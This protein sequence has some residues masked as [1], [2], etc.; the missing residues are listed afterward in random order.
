MVWGLIF[1][2]GVNFIKGLKFYIG[3]ELSCWGEVLRCSKNFMSGSKFRIG[4]VILG[5][6]ILEVGQFNAK[7]YPIGIKISRLTL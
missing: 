4:G 6:K 2:S 5:S 3:G 7:K 1:G